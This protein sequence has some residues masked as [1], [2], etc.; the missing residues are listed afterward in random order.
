MTCGDP[1]VMVHVSTIC[2]SHAFSYVKTL[3]V[4]QNLVCLESWCFLG[5]CSHLMLKLGSTHG[6]ALTEALQPYTSL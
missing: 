3:C 5:L 1:G 2:I 4:F 6:P